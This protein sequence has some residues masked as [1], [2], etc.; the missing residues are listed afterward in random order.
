ME[1]KYILCYLLKKAPQT[2]SQ[3]YL[4]FLLLLRMTGWPQSWPEVLL[5]PLWTYLRSR[6]SARRVGFCCAFS[7][8]GWDACSCSSRSLWIS[9]RISLGGENKQDYKSVIFHKTSSPDIARGET[10]WL[11][12]AL[13]QCRFNDWAPTNKRSPQQWERALDIF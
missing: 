7:G 4:L 10:V 12:V 2:V 3:A 9:C 5:W 11:Y 13:H 1:K 6:N 8:V